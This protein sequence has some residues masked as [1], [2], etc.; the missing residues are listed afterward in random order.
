VLHVGTSYAFRVSPATDPSA[1]GLVYSGD[2]GRA[3]DLLPL[4][5]PGDTL[6]V[7]ASH[8]AGPVIDG[9]N[10]LNAADASGLATDAKAGRLVITHILDDVDPAAALALACERFAGEAMLA[11]P[12]LTLTV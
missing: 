3:A 4:V 11:E 2:C 7:E 10:H 12:G 9:P 6:L 8:G 1:P 5:R